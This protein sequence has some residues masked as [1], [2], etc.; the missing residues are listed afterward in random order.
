[1]MDWENLSFDR[2]TVRDL[3]YEIDHTDPNSRKNLQ[4]A[5]EKMISYLD[6]KSEEELKHTLEQL[7]KQREEI[8]SIPRSSTF[9]NK[10]IQFFV[11]F[12]SDYIV[13]IENRLRKTK[14]L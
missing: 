5:L 2:V 4:K 7:T 3:I 6:E 9:A 14:L 12:L 8:N 13:E 10:R 1:M 11:K